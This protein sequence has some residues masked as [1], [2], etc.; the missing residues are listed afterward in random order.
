MKNARWLGA[1]GRDSACLEFTQFRYP[2]QRNRSGTIPP[3][4]ESG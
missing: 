1:S 3:L 2:A 4:P